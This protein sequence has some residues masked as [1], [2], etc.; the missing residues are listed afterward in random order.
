M[1]PES[2]RWFDEAAGPLVRPYAR[3]GGR[4]AGSARSLDMLTTVV[5][6]P[7]AP[8]LRR[9]ELEYGQIVELCRRPHA[10]AEVSAA[11]RMPLVV[12]KVLIGDLITDGILVFRAPVATDHAPTI[13]LLRAVLDGI[14][15]M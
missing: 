14:R 11:L 2:R 7:A 15:R 10:V 1:N 4:T 3:T 8:M 13:D 9:I 6:S 5:V 12:T